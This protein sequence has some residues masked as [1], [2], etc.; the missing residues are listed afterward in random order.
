M[1]GDPCGFDVRWSRYR[2]RFVEALVRSA[3]CAGGRP[4]PTCTDK[5]CCGALAR[6]C[7]PLGIQRIAIPQS[8]PRLAYRE[9][10]DD[11]AVHPMHD[12]LWMLGHVYGSGDL[13]RTDPFSGFLVEPEDLT[14]IMT[15]AYINEQ[16]ARFFGGKALASDDYVADLLHCIVSV[17][18]PD[19]WLERVHANE[20]V[21]F[22]V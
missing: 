20:L 2:W 3:R 15:S 8:W 6:M 7:E 17:A 4:N 13:R 9:D 21:R 16:R 22:G 11:F 5:D 18:L 10:L 12:A 19:H 14:P 1:T